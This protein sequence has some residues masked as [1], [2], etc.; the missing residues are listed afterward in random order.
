MMILQKY[1][2]ENCY[3]NEINAILAISFRLFVY[4]LLKKR[5]KFPDEIITDM[6]EQMDA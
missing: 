2:M 1:F 3:Y 6:K 5:S 4:S